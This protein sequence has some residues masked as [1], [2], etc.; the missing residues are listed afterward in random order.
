MRTYHD[1]IPC[2]ARQALNDIRNR[3]DELETTE[4][5]GN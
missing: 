5:K 2:F 3:L 1:C 4:S